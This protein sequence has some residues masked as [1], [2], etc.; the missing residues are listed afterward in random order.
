MNF[1]TK[2]IMLIVCL[3]WVGCA[4]TVNE[5]EEPTNELSNSISIE[6]INYDELPASIEEQIA[7]IGCNFSTTKNGDLFYTNGL[8][9]INGLYEM[10]QPVELDNRKKRLFINENWELEIKISFLEV[11]DEAESEVFE[12]EATLKS[13]L[14]GAT[15]TFQVFARCG[16][17]A[18]GC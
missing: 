5:Q 13:R 1:R 10:L 11:I 4:S 3:F 15:K 17:G 6:T 16:V 12:G 14:T 18:W 8:M 2:F 7:F 9:K